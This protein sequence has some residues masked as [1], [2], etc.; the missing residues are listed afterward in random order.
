MPIIGRIP[1][2]GL[3]PE[4]R[5]ALNQMR[6]QPIVTASEDEEAET[7]FAF[8]APIGAPLFDEHETGD[9]IGDSRLKTEP[10]EPPPPRDAKPGIPS[11]DEWMDFFSRIVL[12][13]AC[14]WYIEWA[15]RGVD[16]Q[17]LT[18]RE[19]E[20][21]QLT[22]EERQRIAVPLAE[23]SHKSKLMRRHGRTIVASG[24]V[25]DAIV[26]LGTWT[27]RV[28]RIARKHKPR[29]V[30]GRVANERTGQSEPPSD[31]GGYAGANGGRI[32]DGV[33]IINPGT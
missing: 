25:F 7:E 33:T 23:L 18:D 31:G 19:I 28:N 14:D 1:G 11:L 21:V 3:T 24:G 27:S 13:V 12:R 9:T 26:A 2:Q 29:V 20:R 22:H 17:T 6:D 5:E 30:A 10:K 16:E 4:A 15:F 32:V 8:D